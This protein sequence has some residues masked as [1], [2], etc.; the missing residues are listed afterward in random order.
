MSCIY[1]DY[2]DYNEGKCQLFDPNFEMNGCD[3]EGYCIVDSDPC[4]YNNCE[5]FEPID[6]DEIFDC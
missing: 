1:N 4:P 3:K 6:P 5:D 2:N